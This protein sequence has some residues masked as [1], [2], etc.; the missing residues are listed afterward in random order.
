MGFLRWDKC[1]FKCDWLRGQS[2]GW[3]G[4]SDF[5][6]HIGWWVRLGWGLSEVEVLAGPERFLIDPQINLGLNSIALALVPYR[7]VSIFS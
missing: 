6:F 1:L 3:K 5:R 2:G 7:H 4:I